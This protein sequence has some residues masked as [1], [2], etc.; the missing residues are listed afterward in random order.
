MSIS[1]DTAVAKTISNLGGLQGSA[2]QKEAGEKQIRAMVSAILEEVLK[3]QID[4]TVVVTSGD[5]AGTY[6]GVGTIS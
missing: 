6:A 1:I 4:T 2:E 5:S 3:G